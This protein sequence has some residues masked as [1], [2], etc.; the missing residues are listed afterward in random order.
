MRE[1]LRLRKT[2]T[3]IETQ[4]NQTEAV[5]NTPAFNMDTFHR[6]LQEIKTQVF[7]EAILG[8]RGRRQIESDL[9]ELR[10]SVTKLQ[11]ENHPP[12]ILIPKNSGQEPRVGVFVDVQ[13]IFYAAK[14]FNAR[15]DF[16]KLLKTAVGSRRLV[17]AIAYVVQSPE[18][19]QSG[20]ISM[21]Q[22]KGYEIRRK[23][24]RQ[25][26]DGSAKG[27]WD[28]G[29]TIDI[30]QA[31]NTLD[32]VVLVTGDGDFVP[33]VNCIKNLGPRAEVVS[34]PHNTARDLIHCADSHLPIDENLLMRPGN[35]KIEDLLTEQE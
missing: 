17:R 14:Q 15:L 13:N 24:L 19:D 9:A 29:M 1:L 28:V 10:A 11:E 22:Q 34:F 31:V 12:N 32:V 18:V 16:D 27:D 23:D 2:L 21:L 20:F 33:L 8:E 6:D 35:G 30:I 26:S 25:R 3:R 5:E 7:K 4:L